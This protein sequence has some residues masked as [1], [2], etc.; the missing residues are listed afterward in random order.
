MVVIDTLI[1]VFTP[2]FL[3]QI[4]TL[5]PEEQKMPEVQ[6][7]MRTFV[8]EWMVAALSM[9]FTEKDLRYY[10][11]GVDGEP[12]KHCLEAIQTTQ[13]LDKLTTIEFLAA[14][15]S[16][17]NIYHPHLISPFEQAFKQQ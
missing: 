1:A 3:Q 7:F 6:N 8:K 9:V 14:L 11:Q 13:T 12:Y 4:G 2:M 15:A 5:T 16:Y 17:I 10:I